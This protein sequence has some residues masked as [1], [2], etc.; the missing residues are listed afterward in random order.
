MTNIKFLCF[1]SSIFWLCFATKMVEARRFVCH[2]I[3]LVMPLTDV[4]THTYTHSGVDILLYCYLN[5]ISTASGKKTKM[6]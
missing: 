6:L 1:H 5:I 4:N 3:H 2:D